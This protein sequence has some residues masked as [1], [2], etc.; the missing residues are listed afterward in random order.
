MV[1]KYNIISHGVF[2]P[3]GTDVPVGDTP[4]AKEEVKESVVDTTSEIEESPSVTKKYS[5]KALKTMKK[6]E[7]D[8]VAKEYGISGN[9]KSKVDLV[10]EILRAQ[11][12]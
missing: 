5:T 9:F 6:S 8:E 2:Y 3:A 4:K 10:T 11:G 12:E 1:Y 7:L